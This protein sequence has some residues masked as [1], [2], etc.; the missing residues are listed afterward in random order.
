[1]SSGEPLVNCVIA[2]PPPNEPGEARPPT[3][4]PPLAYR[5][6]IRAWP[7]DVSVVIKMAVIWAAL[8]L[9]ESALGIAYITRQK[10]VAWFS[11]NYN[12]WL[13]VLGVLLRSLLP[14]LLVVGLVGLLKFKRGA[15]RLSVFVAGAF[16][17]FAI[18]ESIVQVVAIVTQRTYAYE[19]P[20]HLLGLV[21]GFIT[22]NALLIILWVMLRRT[23]VKLLSSD[24]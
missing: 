2:R 16:V 8:Q 11:S 22:Q 14:T 21:Q 1:M 3:P 4:Q 20:G 18:V 6:D 12:G 5:G 9:L 24:D 13:Y 7:W 10:N 23:D 17:A 19:I 15:R